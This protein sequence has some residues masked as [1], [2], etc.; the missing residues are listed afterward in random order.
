MHDQCRV[1]ARSLGLAALLNALLAAVEFGARFQWIDSVT[2]VSN[3]LHDLG[4]AVSF[5]V[6]YLLLR[7]GRGKVER[8]ATLFAA[9]VIIIGSLWVMAEAGFRFVF[10]REIEPTALTGVAIFALLV[11][12]WCFWLLHRGQAQTVQV[13][14]WHFVEDF[15]GGMAL[16]ALP[17]LPQ[18][19]QQPW[20]DPAL[21]IAL[22]GFILLMVVRR[23]F[24]ALQGG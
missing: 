7:W 22:Y 16:L 2:L 11:N 20:L 5:A 10:P 24:R 4:D 19:W 18:S 3:A 8:Q 14:K 1:S 21:A 6:I 13:A 23:L 12:G 17:N 9:G 15:S